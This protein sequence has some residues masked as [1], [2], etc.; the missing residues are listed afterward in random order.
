MDRP[1]TGFVPNGG[2]THWR[3]TVV[4]SQAFTLS[5]TATLGPSTHA[6]R[7]LATM[8]SANLDS[9]HSESWSSASLSP[10]R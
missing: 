9:T 4:A 6:P 10:I 7:G 2:Q 5:S 1:L 3:A 8:P